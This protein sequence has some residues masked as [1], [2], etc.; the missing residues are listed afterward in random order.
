MLDWNEPSIAFY[1]AQGARLLDDWTV[2]RVT[3]PALKALAKG[4]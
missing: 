3:G 1:K 2:C 4:G